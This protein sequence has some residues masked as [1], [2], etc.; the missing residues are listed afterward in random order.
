MALR[1][2]TFSMNDQMLK[3]SMTTQARMME[4]QLQQATG[5]KS[6]NYAGLGG[7]ARTVIDMEVSMTRTETYKLAAD[8]ALGRVNAMH[9]QMDTVTKV[10]DDFYKAVTAMRSTSGNAQTFPTLIEEARGLRDHLANNVLNFQHQGRYLF[11]G[12]ATLDP[13]I[14]LTGYVLADPPVANTD[15]YKGDDYIAQVQVSQDHIVSY[16]IT[17]DDPAFELAIRALS[18]IADADPATINDDLME[19]A[20]NL[21]EKALDSAIVVQNRLGIDAR[22]LERASGAQDDYKFFLESNLAPIKGV[23]VA[24]LAVK[25]A[26]FDSQLQASYAAL[27]KIQ[28]ISLV[29]YLR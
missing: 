7:A 2:A 23:D 8:T 11:G 5:E 24:A 25:L 26:A 4:M 29:D 3:A 12:S 13:P 10:I 6:G 18:M 1:V 9:G 17:A 27:A 20:Q 15:Y 14:D 16:G 21:A 19:E 28:S 22:T